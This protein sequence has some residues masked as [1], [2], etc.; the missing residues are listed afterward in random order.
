MGEKVYDNQLENNVTIDVSN[1][2]SGIYFCSLANNKVNLIPIKKV[3]IT[4]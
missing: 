3:V 4:H 1:W 2:P